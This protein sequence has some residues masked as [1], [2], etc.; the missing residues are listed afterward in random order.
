MGKT[1]ILS[2]DLDTVV[3]FDLN[4]KER[5]ELVNNILYSYLTGD[6]L[7]KFTKDFLKQIKDCNLEHGKDKEIDKAVSF[8]IKNYKKL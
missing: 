6:N 4:N 2:T 7:Q 1:I 3:E 5:I 8:L